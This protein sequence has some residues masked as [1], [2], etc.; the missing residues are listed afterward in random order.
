MLPLILGASL[1]FF[2]VAGCERDAHLAD[3]HVR[4]PDVG[5]VTAFGHRLDKDASIQEVVYV[6]LQAVVADYDAGADRKAREEAMDIQLGVAAPQYMRQIGEKTGRMHG[7]DPDEYVF[8][9][10][11]HWAPVLGFYVDDFRVDF[12]TLKDR[13]GIAPEA[14]A[15]D[16]PLR[17]E[18][19]V[20]VAHP[21][22]E[23]RPGGNVVAHLGM[24]REKGFWRIWYVG[25]EN[26]TRDWKTDSPDAVRA[27][28]AANRQAADQPAPAN[29][30]ND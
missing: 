25:W 18:V 21:D 17:A 10:V 7:H 15:Q 28:V 8:D 27:A 19:F 2:A 3:L 4:V 23:Q 13:M 6:F 12:D 16:Q 20:N 26:T 24:V 1:A 30:D 29:S 22:P 9:S 14:P 5:P 11:R